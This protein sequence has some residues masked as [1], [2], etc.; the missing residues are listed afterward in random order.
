MLKGN[1]MVSGMLL[2]ALIGAAISLFDK[3]TRKTFIH[4]SKQIGNKT[5][6][7][8]KNP[9]VVANQVK[10]NVNAFRSTFSEV[11]EDVRFLSAKINELNETT[12]QMLNMIKDA[13]ETFSK[14]KEDANGEDNSIER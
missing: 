4:N 11:A 3:E 7:M 14:Q 9:E 2:G 13:K 10:K 6:K 1:K 5:A 12:P 8:I